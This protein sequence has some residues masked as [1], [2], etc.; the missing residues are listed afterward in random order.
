MAASLYRGLH[1][2]AE[3]TRNGYA[4][5]TLEDWCRGSSDPHFVVDARGRILH[6]GSWTGY[7]AEELVSVSPAS[8]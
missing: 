1:F 7:T 8:P 5:H 4:L 3:R 2:V 6:Q